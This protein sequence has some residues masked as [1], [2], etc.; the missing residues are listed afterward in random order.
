LYKISIKS[1]KVSRNWDW[2]PLPLKR[3]EI[4]LCSFV[5]GVDDR[6]I[7]NNCHSWHIS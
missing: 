5:A 6:G 4:K 2:V 3:E 1:Q 7:T